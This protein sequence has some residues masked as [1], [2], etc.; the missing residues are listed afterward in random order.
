[1]PVIQDSK[2]QDDCAS[3]RAGGGI[4]IA[5]MTPKASLFDA[6][7]RNISPV[8]DT[9]HNEDALQTTDYIIDCLKLISDKRCISD[10]LSELELIILALKNP[11]NDCMMK[12]NCNIVE[13]CV[14]LGADLF[15]FVFWCCC[16]QGCSCSLFLWMF[17]RIS[18]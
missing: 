6:E 12:N 10:R 5:A 17:C 13:L 15:C 16:A 14:N 18:L 4:T 2:S 11:F 8:F 3:I 1:M 9:E 7:C